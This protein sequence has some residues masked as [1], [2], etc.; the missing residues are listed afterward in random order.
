MTKRT[1]VTTNGSEVTAFD[2]ETV[3][4]IDDLLEELRSTGAIRIP[5]GGDLRKGA[6]MDKIQREGFVLAAYVV[7]IW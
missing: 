5:V 6:A 4:S 3:K 1:V 2:F 7:S